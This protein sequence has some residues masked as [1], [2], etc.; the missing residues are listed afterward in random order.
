MVCHRSE[1]KEENE[2]KQKDRQKEGITFTI[3]FPVKN[4][5]EQKDGIKVDPPIIQTDSTPS[6]FTSNIKIIAVEGRVMLAGSNELFYSVNAGE[7]GYL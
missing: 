4:E 7:L 6:D 1:G 3:K 2:R 5:A